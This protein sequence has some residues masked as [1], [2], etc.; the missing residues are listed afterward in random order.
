[1]SW[2]KAAHETRIHFPRPE[3]SAQLRPSVVQECRGS[4]RARGARRQVRRRPPGEKLHAR[5]TGH[6]RRACISLNRDVA[7][8]VKT[9]ERLGFRNA[10]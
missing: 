2:E 4:Q 5:L 1:M 10:N 9:D 8:A 6:E 7:E 3:Q